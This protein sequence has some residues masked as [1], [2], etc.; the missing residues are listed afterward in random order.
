MDDAVPLHED[1][2]TRPATK[3][4]TGL[5]WSDFFQSLGEGAPS[6]PKP[7]RPPAISRFAT[8]A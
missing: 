6:Q 1:G 7:V 5:G 2:A 3:H 8:S 4:Q